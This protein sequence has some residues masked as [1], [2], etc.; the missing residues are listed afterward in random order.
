MKILLFL[1]LSAFSANAS[2]NCLQEHEHEVLHML[3][4]SELQALLEDK[5]CSVAE[6]I[7]FGALA[8]LKDEVETLNKGGK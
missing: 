2:E 4:P 5:T 1:A 3:E 7:D 6:G 8:D